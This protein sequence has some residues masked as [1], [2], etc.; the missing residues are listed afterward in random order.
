MQGKAAIVLKKLDIVTKKLEGDLFWEKV[1]PVA[2]LQVGLLYFF[3]LWVGN[4]TN[5]P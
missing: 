2:Q 3:S 1:L 4:E 5:F